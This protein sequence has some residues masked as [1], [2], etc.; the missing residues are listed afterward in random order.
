MDMSLKK[1]THYKTGNRNIFEHPIFYLLQGIFSD[2][3]LSLTFQ[4]FPLLVRTQGNTWSGPPAI[5][6][7]SSNTGNNNRWPTITAKY[8]Q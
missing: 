3:I 5:A 6:E 4:E 8:Q 7:E 2:R 1:K